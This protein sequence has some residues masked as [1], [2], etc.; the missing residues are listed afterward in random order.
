MICWY[1]GIEKNKSYNELQA[2][3]EMSD[4]PD[5][6][7]NGE[8]LMLINPGTINIGIVQ[9]VSVSYLNREQEYLEKFQRQLKGKGIECQWLGTMI[10]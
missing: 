1:L 9:V 6:S 7:E 2:V 8:G 10:Q 5:L 4:I 3:L